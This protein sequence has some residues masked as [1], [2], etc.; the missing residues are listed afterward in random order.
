MKLTVKIPGMIEPKEDNIEEHEAD[1]TW[2]SISDSL[3][4]NIWID[5]DN[6]FKAAVYPVKDGKTDTSNGGTPCEIVDIAGDNP[7]QLPSRMAVYPVAAYPAEFMDYNAGHDKALVAK[8][9]KIIKA[10][11]IH[12][13]LS[14]ILENYCDDQ[15][16]S[17]ILATIKEAQPQLGD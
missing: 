5:K 13:A 4:L 9:N 8:M 14:L 1:D 15:D 16:L 17:G 6:N 2:A 11:G 12:G 7:I 10:I 3:D